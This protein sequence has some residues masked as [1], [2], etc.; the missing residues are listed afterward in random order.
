MFQFP[1]HKVIFISFLLFHFIPLNIFSLQKWISTRPL[2]YQSGHNHTIIMYF[3]ITGYAVEE[4]RW[5]LCWRQWTALQWRYVGAMASNI[6]GKSA[7]CSDL[8]KE[9]TKAPYNWPFVR[10]T[11]RWPGD[12]LHKGPTMRE[13]SLRHGTVIG[14]AETSCYSWK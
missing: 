5:C 13:S 3:V 8:Q 11:K 12:S 14:R 4:P 6:I 1:F 10:R 7:V 2:L 9:I